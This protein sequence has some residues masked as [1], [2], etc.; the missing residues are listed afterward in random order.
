MPASPLLERPRASSVPAPAGTLLIAGAGS[1]GTRHLR[2][3]HA[4]GVRDLVVFRTGEGPVAAGFTPAVE[5]DWE[6]ALD[7]RPLATLVCNPTALHVPTALSAARA[8]S[9]LFLEKPLSH[10]LEGVG[11]LAAE[12]RARG[13]VALVGFQFRFHPALRQVKTWLEE[14]AVGEVAT[15][16]AVWGEY[17]PDWHPGEDYRTS[18]SA[19]RD[20]GGGALL[21][22]C[23]PF[24]YLR[25]LLGEAESV[26]AMAGQR[27]GLGLDVEDVAHVVVRFASGALGAVSLDYVARPPTHRLE[28]VGQHGIVE[29]ADGDGV[30][31]LLGRDGRVR[32]ATPPR[33]F[34]RN[35]M[36]VEEMAHFLRCLAGRET[37][38][39][40][41]ADGERA[42][43]MALAARESAEAGR[44]TLV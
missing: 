10:R 22:L 11:E 24:D 13:L 6:R 21:T 44:R 26:Q 3:L 35:E 23:H 17:L 25:F 37:P 42:L 27:S 34:S 40:T 39:C 20:L 12:V 1:V 9:H 36:F 5:R 30:A 33:G 2:N 15:A 8:G 38:A 7:R 43:R 32:N 19:R 4:L 31:R 29:W 14:G 18:Y 41:L 16:R 28:I